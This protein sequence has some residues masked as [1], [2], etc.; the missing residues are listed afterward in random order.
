VLGHSLVLL[1]SSFLPSREM[2]ASNPPQSL[3]SLATTASSV[4]EGQAARGLY[5]QS[6]YG[7]HAHSIRTGCLQLQVS[8]VTSTDSTSLPALSLP[9]LVLLTLEESVAPVLK[10]KHTCSNI[11]LFPI[12][13][14]SFSIEVPY[15]LCESLGDIRALFLQYVPDVVGGNN[16]RLAALKSTGNAKQSYD[17]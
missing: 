8:Y 5:M 14:L 16:V 9:L 7:A 3:V 2:A 11:R 6:Y 1:P 4:F 15:R 12:T 13:H 10:I 17:I